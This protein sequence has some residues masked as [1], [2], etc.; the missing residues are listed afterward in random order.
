MLVI[1]QLSAA[2]VARSDANLVKRPNGNLLDRLI[3]AA[4]A[5]PV[6]AYL[7]P[8]GGAL[9]YN[10]KTGSMTFRNLKIRSD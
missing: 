2:L 4:T 5:L 1:D 10:F 6:N 8:S 7:P 3:E 9:Q